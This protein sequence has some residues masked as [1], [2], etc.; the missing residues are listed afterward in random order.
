MKES[1]RRAFLDK[2]FDGSL[3]AIIFT[4]EKGYITE[5]NK[6]FTELTG[7]NKEEIIGKHTVE[8][9]PMKEGTY[10]CTTGELIQ[11]DKK[12]SDY[13]KSSMDSF[14]E[15]GKLHNIMGFQLRK[16]GKVVPVEDNM[17]FLLG[18]NGERIGAFAVIRDIT[19]REKI[20]KES[21]ERKE[22]LEN[23]IESS[24]DG[25]VV[26]DN[27]GYITRVNK[28]FLNML[29]YREEEIIGKHIIECSP[30]EEGNYNSITGDSIQIND[31]YF[32]SMKTAMAS[33]LHDGKVI[34]RKTFYLT[35]D[36]KLLPAEESLVFL[37][38][39]KGD[40]V[41]AVGVIRDITERMKA[42]ELLRESEEKYYT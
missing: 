15:K 7:Y 9:S 4:D 40:R 17:V 29:G 3:D 21:R 36:K 14:L 25:I 28:A 35:K 41:G 6:A 26:S 30:L 31:N 33:F 38:D 22:F 2:T 1:D 37:F 27:V 32:I 39:T 24:L 12:F 5:A 20:L 13:I 19:E 23:I 34:N 10:K 11:I 42:E 8:F 18:D 16:D